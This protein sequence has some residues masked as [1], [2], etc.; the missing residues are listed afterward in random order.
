MIEG[1][2]VVQLEQIIANAVKT[3]INSLLDT[4]GVE[5][6]ILSVDETA[7]FLNLSKSAL[8][9]KTSH[10]TI[11]CYKK[12]KRVYFKRKELEDWISTGKN[13]Y[14]EEESEIEFTFPK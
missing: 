3:Q 1:I 5:K 6:Q 2:T 9:K 7:T 13:E 14:K 12:N 11:P 10:K 4:Q 8:Y